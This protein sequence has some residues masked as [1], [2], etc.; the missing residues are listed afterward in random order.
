MRQHIPSRNGKLWKAS[1]F[2]T[3][4]ISPSPEYDLRT[5]SP[6]L[7]TPQEYTRRGG[8]FF[9]FSPKFGNKA[10]HVQ[11]EARSAEFGR[12]FK[13]PLFERLRPRPRMSERACQTERRSRDLRARMRRTI[14]WLKKSNGVWAEKYQQQ[15]QVRSH[16]CGL[17]VK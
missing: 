1:Q 15:Q 13:Q 3:K 12:G 9:F 5:Q 11:S 6:Y 17:T 16:M 8:D 14:R 7:A 10:Q 2:T 4:M